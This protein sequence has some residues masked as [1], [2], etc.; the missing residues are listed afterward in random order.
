MEVADDR[1]YVLALIEV[2]G[3]EEVLSGHA[4]LPA[5][6]GIEGEGRERGGQSLMSLA[7]AAW[8][9]LLDVAACLLLLLRVASSYLHASM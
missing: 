7:V 8:L 3:H 1:A 5:G 2:D 6:A 4:E 9:L